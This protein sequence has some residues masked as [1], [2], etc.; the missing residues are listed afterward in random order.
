[1]KWNEIKAL[2]IYKLKDLLKSINIIQKVSKRRN[3]K[4]PAKELY[5]S[6]VQVNKK[7]KGH[8]TESNLFRDSP[9][10]DP[11]SF[12]NQSTELW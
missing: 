1:M 4:I 12:C 9:H 3:P 8:R 7:K 10:P 11:A 2:P 6:K 5:K